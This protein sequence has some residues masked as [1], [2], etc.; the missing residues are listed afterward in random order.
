MRRV[1]I[2]RRL[3]EVVFRGQLEGWSWTVGENSSI[4]GRQEE[5]GGDRSQFMPIYRYGSLL[6][7]SISGN[8]IKSLIFNLY[9]FLNYVEYNWKDWF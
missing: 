2:L 4:T 8:G 5:I 7:I 1:N 3:K 6:C 9:L